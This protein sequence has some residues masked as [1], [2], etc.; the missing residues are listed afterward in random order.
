MSHS[1][2]VE[3]PTVNRKVAGSSPAGTVNFVMRR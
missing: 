2:M 3:R 1:S